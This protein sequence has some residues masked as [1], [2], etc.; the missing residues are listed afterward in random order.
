MMRAKPSLLAQSQLKVDKIFLKI[1]YNNFSAENDFLKDFKIREVRKAIKLERS[2]FK[3]IYDIAEAEEEEYSASDS[4]KN[5][6]I[7]NGSIKNG[8]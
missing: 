6:S 8:I 7:K 4:I 1:Y 2:P 5:G 3:N